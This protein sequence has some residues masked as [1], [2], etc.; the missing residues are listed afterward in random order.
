MNCKK[1]LQDS[2][3][4]YDQTFLELELGKL[5]PAR[6]SLVGDIPAGDGKSP[7]LYLQCA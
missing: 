7:N 5:F 2:W 6:E 4:Y 3:I 1:K